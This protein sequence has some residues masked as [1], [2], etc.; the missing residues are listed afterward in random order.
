[1][2]LLV[3]SDLQGIDHG[4]WTTF[5]HM[6]PSHYDATVLLGDIEELHLKTIH[7]RFSGKPLFGVLGNHDYEGDLEYFGIEDIHGR[8]IQVSSY[9]FAGLKGSVRYK[10]GD[11]PMLSQNEATLICRA[12]DPVD[13]LVSHNSPKGVHDKPDAAHEGFEG[14]LEYIRANKPKYSLHGHQ[15]KNVMTCL[16]TTK[17]IGVYGAIILDTVTGDRN[18]V[19]H[20]A[21]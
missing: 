14:I 18:Q 7:E 13:I 3:L 4:E 1:M 2:K 16:G 9:R 21:E 19:L 10:P 8:E 17:V 5:I 20:V 15:H 11:A 6:D 12:F